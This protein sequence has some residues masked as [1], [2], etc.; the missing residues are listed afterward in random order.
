LKQLDFERLDVN[1][2]HLFNGWLVIL[3]HQGILHANLDQQLLGIPNLGL[4]QRPHLLEN[5]IQILRLLLG[6][7]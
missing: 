5:F 6:F 4:Y 2:L 3:H 7:L 1:R